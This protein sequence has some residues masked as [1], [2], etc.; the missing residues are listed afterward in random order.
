MPRELDRS[1]LPLRRE[2]LTRSYE[3]F[4][5]DL[6]VA[7][8]P[9]FLREAGTARIVTCG[10]AQV[11]KSTLVLA[12]MG[13]R[14][15]SMAEVSQALRGGRA[16]GRSSTSTPTRY[17]WSVDDHWRVGDED[18]DVRLIGAEFIDEAVT[19]GRFAIEQGV[20]PTAAI[21]IH[22][23]LRFRDPAVDLD[24]VVTDLPGVGAD[25]A[26]EARAARAL[27][28]QF[29]AAA[30]VILAVLKSDELY[31]LHPSTAL[32]A[33]LAPYALL[34]S[35]FRLVLT[36]A[37]QN[38]NAERFT[39]PSLA[40]LLEHYHH[41]LATHDYDMSSPLGAI[42]QNS[43]YLFDG[44]D[45]RPDHADARNL[46]AAVDR[47]LPLLRASFAAK[48]VESTRYVT[49]A[50]SLTVVSR[51]YDELVTQAE[52][53]RSTAVALYGQL[54]ENVSKAAA[55]REQACKALE[56]REAAL[57]A[58]TDLALPAIRFSPTLPS[59]ERV[60]G[61]AARAARAKAIRE[62]NAATKRAWADFCDRTPSSLE[63]PR[64][65]S[66]AATVEA[67]FKSL[68]CGGCG[69]GWSWFR[70]QSSHCL[71]R[72]RTDSREAVKK[73]NDILKTA[74]RHAI[75]PVLAAQRSARNRAKGK[76]ERAEAA[77][78]DARAALKRAMRSVA[79]T[80]ARVQ[81]AQAQAEQ[82]TAQARD[83][84]RAVHKEYRA[85][86]RSTLLAM[87][88]S[89]H[90]QRRWLLALTA[91]RDHRDFTQLI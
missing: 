64:W 13:V 91:L 10:A 20:V 88:D 12:L 23:P 36:H 38:L 46:T 33:V 70:H 32:G 47:S 39:N 49:A 90:Q 9:H 79:S 16:R 24:T 66:L 35:R 45:N 60:E 21:D 75:N 17:S 5:Q 71:D 27:L 43:L 14:S 31:G 80:E 37:A 3:A 54:Q 57:A 2:W 7:L 69:F 59:P 8:H 28:E 74:A 65:S 4:L 86:R 52:E 67:S 81:E 41:E 15:E 1:D 82:A 48:L 40:H 78:T 55:L 50:Q 85:S 29:A 26:L 58:I 76:V 18:G 51:Y 63:T 11:G 73:N 83:F 30:D 77:S 87:R 44:G 42:L 22:I 84:G 72:T 61:D 62:L 89:P 6:P 68:C 25:N 19:E 53:E 34:E 56:L